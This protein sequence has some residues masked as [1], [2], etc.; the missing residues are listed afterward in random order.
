MKFLRPTR[1][2]G[3][4]PKPQRSARTF[5]MLPQAIADFQRQRN[6][7]AEERLHAGGGWTDEGLVFAAENG[8]PLRLS[9]VDRAFRRIRDRVRVRPLPTYSLRHGCPPAHPARREQEPSHAA[10]PRA[11]ATGGGRPRWQFR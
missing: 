5:V 10:R 2:V 9:N 4:L 11:G 1:L 8:L 7:Q 3:G 6:Q